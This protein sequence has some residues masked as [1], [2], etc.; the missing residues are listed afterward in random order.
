MASACLRARCCQVFRSR[1]NATRCSPCSG[2]E[3]AGGEMLARVLAGFPPPGAEVSGTVRTGTIE[4]GK[5]ARVVYLPPPAHALAPHA[6]VAGQLARA[7]ATRQ[8]IPHGSA[9]EELSLA[10]GRLD[11]APTIDK[12]RARPANLPPLHVAIGLL[13][14]ALA[15]HPALV[16]A[17]DP[18]QGLDPIESETLLALLMARQQAMPFAL[19]Y[20]T[21]DPQ[22]RGAARLPHR[23]PARRKARRRRARCAHARGSGSSRHP[24]PVPRRPAPRSGDAEPHGA[25]D[26]NRCCRSAASCSPSHGVRNAC[27]GSISI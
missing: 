16:I 17:A 3:G 8:Q 15:Q 25:E 24:K 9:H 1:S 19:V 20:A 26:P 5:A 4:G 10:L 14:L 22:R 13:A 11:G 6:G 23:H 21:G 27:R 2:R 12:L 18:A 7:L